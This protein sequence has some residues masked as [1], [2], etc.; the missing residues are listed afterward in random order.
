MRERDQGAV[1]SPIETDNVRTLT[2][3]VNNPGLS[4]YAD[5][6]PLRLIPLYRDFSSVSVED[7]GT[8]K[9]EVTF[10]VLLGL[11]LATGRYEDSII[12]L[13]H[14]RAFRIHDREKF[15]AEVLLH[16][17]STSSFDCFMARAREYGFQQIEGVDITLYHE[18]R[19]IFCVK[20]SRQC[21]PNKFDTFINHISRMSSSSVPTDVHSISSLAL[22]QDGAERDGWYRRR[23]SLAPVAQLPHGDHM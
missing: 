10:P 21:F 15:R 7:D 5:T 1:A 18:V 17:F 3:G 2:D 8:P 20:A 23:R 6:D 12:W 16:F 9:N 19:I 13:P 22:L 4:S 11:I 14:G